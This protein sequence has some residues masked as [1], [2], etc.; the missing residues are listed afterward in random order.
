MAEEEE[1]IFNSFFNF[2]KKVERNINVK[3]TIDNRI[4]VIPAEPKKVVKRENLGT[5]YAPK[6]QRQEKELFENQLLNLPTCSSTSFDDIESNYGSS[7][8]EDLDEAMI[9]I[10]NRYSFKIDPII[11]DLPIFKKKERIL[12]EIRMNNIIIITGHTGSGIC[13]FGFFIFFGGK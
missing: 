4:K 7:E 8:I 1:D 11:P 10:Y 13:I 2:S 6:Y 3:G 9:D 5:S 12:E